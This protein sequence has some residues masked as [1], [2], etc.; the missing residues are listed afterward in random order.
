AL[1]PADVGSSPQ[2]RTPEGV[3]DLA[4][5]VS[6]WVEDAFLSPFYPDCGSC[7]NPVSEP[8]D[9]AAD[10]YRVFRGGAWSNT[11]ASRTSA[12]GRWLEAA[13]GQFLGVRCAA[14]AE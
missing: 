2:D 3:V 8:A 11:I 13:P 9:G 6:E 14:S 1:G 10:V 12:R 5:N 4:G 7:E